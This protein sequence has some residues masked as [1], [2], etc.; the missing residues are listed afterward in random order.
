MNSILKV[1]N[2]YQSYYVENTLNEYVG[3]KDIVIITTSKGVE[4]C[5]VVSILEFNIEERALLDEFKLLRLANENDKKKQQESHVKKDFFSDV[6]K[7]NVTELKLDMR[8]VDI[9]ISHNA[10][11]VTFYYRAEGRIDF[12]ELVKKLAGVVKARVELRQ[13]SDR[14]RAKLI[15]GIGPC[16]YELCC[17]NFL[18]EFATVNVKMAKIQQLSFNLQRVTGLCDRLLCCLKYEN[19][20]Y[21]E[22]K[23]EVPDVG[24]HIILNDGR[25]AKVQA[26][27]LISRYITLKYEDY[28]V[29]ILDFEEFF[30]KYT[31]QNKGEGIKKEWK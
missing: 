26:L 21:I 29:E 31:P 9:H 11:R 28:T 2:K 25:S 15:G 27:Q 14:D 13:V 12:R 4:M 7:Q 20:Q 23:K 19:D 1:Q 5:T 30:K 22:M 18:Q 17:S 16:G 24:R 6:F 3:V 8:L 10:D